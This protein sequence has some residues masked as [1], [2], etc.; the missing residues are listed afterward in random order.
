MQLPEMHKVIATGAGFLLFASIG[1]GLWDLFH[2]LH[3]LAAFIALVLIA[4]GIF[5]I[6][7]ALK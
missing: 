1:I 5:N 2:G 3:A 7:G 6:W 4:A